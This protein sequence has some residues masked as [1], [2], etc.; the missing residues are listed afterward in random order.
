MG[1]RIG[2]DV[3]EIHV[4]SHQNPAFPLAEQCQ[5]RVSAATV[6]LLKHSRCVV[7]GLTQELSYF[8]R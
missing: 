4:Q 7:P 1:R 8:N 6:G 3:G 5:S 2:P